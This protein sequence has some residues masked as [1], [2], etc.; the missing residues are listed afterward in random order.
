M[1]SFVGHRKLEHN[2]WDVEEE[3]VHCN[4]SQ[5]EF[6][7]SVMESRPDD[8]VQARIEH[9]REPGY[10]P[11]PADLR[12]HGRKNPVAFRDAEFEHETDRVDRSAPGAREHG[13]KI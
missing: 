13:P 12:Q 2:S 6:E 3:G 9:N 8:E 1:C 4:H 10:H 5:Y 7:R 11:N